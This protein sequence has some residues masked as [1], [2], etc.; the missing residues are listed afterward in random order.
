MTRKFSLVIQAER[1]RRACGHHVI[2]QGI[3]V[4]KM[5]VL[6]QFLY[7]LLIYALFWWFRTVFIYL[8]DIYT[9]L[10]V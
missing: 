2:L 10:V 4:S 3:V 5:G 7:I 6:G 8:A 9:F 1:T